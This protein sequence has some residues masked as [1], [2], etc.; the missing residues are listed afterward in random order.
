NGL[1]ISEVMEEFAPDLVITDIIMPESDGLETIN[2][3]RT[4]Y[5]Q[6]QIIAISG[7]G[8]QI[9]LDHLPMARMLGAAL[10]LK[11]PIDN[12]QLIEAVHQV[13]GD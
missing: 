11:K 1:H 8:L 6:V 3:L 13:T 12:E 7:G 2:R 5:P 9:S 4:E 10:T